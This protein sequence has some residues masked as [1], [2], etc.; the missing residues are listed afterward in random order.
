M[1][2]IACDMPFTNCCGLTLMAWVAFKFSISHFFWAISSVWACIFLSLLLPFFFKQVLLSIDAPEKLTLLVADLTFGVFIYKPNME[3]HSVQN[4]VKFILCP[5]VFKKV[6]AITARVWVMKLRGELYFSTS[7]T[8]SFH[9]GLTLIT[10]QPKIWSSS[11]NWSSVSWGYKNLWPMSWMFC[12]FR[13]RS[14]GALS[15]PAKST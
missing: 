8:S 13:M 15:I 1:L 12:W 11:A 3:M 10:F 2:D 5:C 9:E 14:W 4:W 7:F 6:Y